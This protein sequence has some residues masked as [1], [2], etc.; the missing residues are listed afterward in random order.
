MSRY[1]KLIIRITESKLFQSNKI[2]LGK[3]SGNDILTPTLPSLLSVR[4]LRQKKTVEKLSELGSSPLRYSIQKWM[5][6]PRIDLRIPDAVAVKQ[7]H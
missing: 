4:P 3:T 2:Q 5:K 6:L 1:N 7:H